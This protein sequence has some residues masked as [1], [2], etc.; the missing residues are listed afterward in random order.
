MRTTYLKRS[1]IA[2]ATIALLLGT[3]ACAGD[4]EVTPT[5]EPA[6]AGGVSDNGGAEPSKKESGD[7]SVVEEGAA[8]K[9]C[10]VEEGS[11][12]LPNEA[13]A[14]DTWEDV[15]GTPV[16][17][18]E[19]YG[20]QVRDGSDGALWR[21]YE[22][23]PTGALFATFYVFVALGNVDGVADE[24]IAD[25]AVKEQILGAEGDDEGES[26]PGSMTPIAYRFVSY[27]PDRA[28][29]DAV[30]EYGDESGTTNISMR[31]PLIWENDSW[32]IDAEHYIDSRPTP[33]ETLDGYVRWSS[34]G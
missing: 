20:P 11:V 13:P 22:H 10:D 9:D 4:E 14:V 8:A 15:E 18:S 31:F 30:M 1:T 27:S 26:A 2:V 5:L 32:K 3:A 24:W 25:S 19:I 17:T 12:A 33:L 21:C 29:I 34:D 23:S 28:V 16:P 7:S 6:P